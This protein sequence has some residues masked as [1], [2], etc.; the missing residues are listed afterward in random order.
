MLALPKEAKVAT[1][2]W[3]TLNKASLDK[4]KKNM[5][6]LHGLMSSI[7]P[8]KD[9]YNNLVRFRKKLSTTVINMEPL[10]YPE[11]IKAYVD[12]AMVW[13]VKALVDATTDKANYATK[14]ESD[15]RN[16]HRDK[17]KQLMDIRSKVDTFGR[18]G[19]DTHLNDEQREIYDNFQNPNSKLSSDQDIDDYLHMLEQIKNAAITEKKY[20]EGVLDAY[21][22]DKRIAPPQTL[23]V[24]LTDV[25]N[26]IEAIGERSTFNPYSLYTTIE[27]LI[28]ILSPN[29]PSNGG[30]R[31]TNKKR[32]TRRKKRRGKKRRS[33]RTKR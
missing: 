17:Q 31:R 7:S 29:K 32:S 33:Y 3:K 25:N 6:D 14:K 30:R 23:S 1:L 22:R 12:S 9:T 26:K 2:D 8:S 16:F 28:S 20:F 10:N 13:V 5:F 15:E 24:A 11:D 21:S 19:Y 27:D 18:D 4:L